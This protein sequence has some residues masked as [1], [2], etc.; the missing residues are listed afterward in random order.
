MRWPM[1][2]TKAPARSQRASSVI[3]ALPVI[4]ATFV[5]HAMLGRRSRQLKMP[6]PDA[7]SVP[8]SPACARAAG[9]GTGSDGC[10]RRRAKRANFPG[11]DDTTAPCFSPCPA[12]RPLGPVTCSS[13]SSGN[14]VATAGTQVRVTNQAG[15]R[16]VGSQAR[17]GNRA[18]DAT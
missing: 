9:K 16:S 13:G 4:A 15:R 18:D 11:A 1:Q 6:R 12:G 3:A 8:P 2:A 10:N 5:M 7:Y 17:C 14:A